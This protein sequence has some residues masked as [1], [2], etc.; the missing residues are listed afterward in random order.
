MRS[1]V[2]GCTLLL[3]AALG[4]VAAHSESPIERAAARYERRCHV[5]TN[6]GPGRKLWWNAGE[7]YGVATDSAACPD[8]D[9]QRID[10]EANIAEANI[11]TSGAHPRLGGPFAKILGVDAIVIDSTGTRARAGT[12]GPWLDLVPLDAGHTI[13][14]GLGLEGRLM[15][16]DGVFRTR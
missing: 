10:A 4:T 8:L 2:L 16:N 1:I 6:P 11:T 15:W 7:Q 9:R 5:E 14:Y 3:L 12:R 13:T